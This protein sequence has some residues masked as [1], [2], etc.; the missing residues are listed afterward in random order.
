MSSRVDCSTRP[1][2]RAAAAGPHLRCPGGSPRRF[3]RAVGP[4]DVSVRP[5]LPADAAE[6]ARIQLV[7][8]RTAY[9]ALLPAAVLDDWDAAAATRSLARRGHPPPTPGHGVLVAL[10]RNY[11]SSGSPPTARPS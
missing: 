3:P 11:A 4:A 5:A 6:I 10:E 1:T 8:W 7:T 9:R 2:A